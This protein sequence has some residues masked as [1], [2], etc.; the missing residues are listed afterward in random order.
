MADVLDDQA[1][2]EGL[3]ELD[4]WQGS[5]EKIAKTFTFDDFA[6]S[7]AFVNRVAAIAEEL[8]HHPDIRISWNT[9]ELEISS[10]AAGGVTATCLDLARRIANSA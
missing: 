9:V 5:T 6:G 3:A 4:G 8:D 10:H 7:M 2:R 1:V